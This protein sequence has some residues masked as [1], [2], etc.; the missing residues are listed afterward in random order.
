MRPLHIISIAVLLSSACDSS[1][2]SKT[3][4]GADDVDAAIDAPAC[5][6]PGVTGCA[7]S[8]VAPGSGGRLVPSRPL[9]RLVSDPTRCLIYGLADDAVLVFDTKAKTEL[10]P[11]ALSAPTI[12]IDISRDGA[13]LVVAHR[14]AKKLSVID[15]A[16]R[17]VSSVISI[18][19]EPGRVELTSGGVAY[20]ANYDQ[21]T[22][23][24]RVDLATTADTVVATNIG[25]QMD[26]DLSADD[27]RLYAGDSGISSSA[28]KAFD[29][30]GGMFTQ[31]GRTRWNRNFDFPDATR[32]VRATKSNNIYF[33]GH[34]W[35]NGSLDVVTG[36]PLEDILAEDD[37][38][39]IAIGTLHAWD[40]ALSAATVTFVD[41][42]TAAAFTAAGQEAWM[43]ST[44][45]L[46]PVLIFQ[47]I[48]QLRGTHPL[49]LRDLPPAQLSTYSFDQ[50]VHDPA[51]GLLYGRDTNAQAIVAIDTTTLQPTKEIRVGSVPSDMAIDPANNALY[52]GHGEIQ[53]LARINLATLTFDKF[54]QTPR[55]PFQV[56][57]A[58]AGRVI[59]ADNSYDSAPTLFDVATMQAAP[60][61]HLVD[62]AAISVTPDG[63]MLFAA[64]MM[65]S[66]PEIFRF[67]IG[68]SNLAL[69]T[70][71]STNQQVGGPL[72][73][74]VPHPAGT[75]VFLGLGALDGST[76]AVRYSTATRVLSMSP[77]GR[78]ALSA[79]NVY[80]VA[81]GADL[82][83]LP[84][85][86]PVHAI[87][88]NSQKAYLWT[89]STIMPVSL[90][91]F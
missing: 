65:S 53:A 43:Y 49:G 74:I 91:A 72:R 70:R 57:P 1:D 42:P 5:T 52:V 19:V 4:G 69:I 77:D 64:T 63:T 27:T 54:I 83:A 58:G 24:H 87:D 8:P 35:R 89:S 59:T 50:L 36:G 31:V 79:T 29:I 47:N 2:S 10:A 90:S 56:E 61:T 3:D 88:A 12:D 75:T 55:L 39:T 11:I 28:M 38:G 40:V 44:S 13:R 85:N 26:I 73:V 86:A 30:S 17:Q 48:A 68:S 16:Q 20:Y 41:K 25:Y 46:G 45:T 66:S 33:A 62:F 71:V 34:Q 18:L 81:T 82:G 21:W 9:T 67:T 80:N 84:L 76:F 78:V 23:M 22:S 6:D 14:F 7:C 32:H 15:L 51:R 60:T 37:A